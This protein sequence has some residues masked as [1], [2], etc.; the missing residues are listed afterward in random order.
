VSHP[1]SLDVSA[2]VLKAVTGWIARHRRRP[3]SRPAQRAGTVH[4]Q[5]TLVLRWL[6]HRLD[7]RTLAADAGL[8]MAT[9]YRYLHE[10]L[11]VIADHSPTLDDVLDR[12]HAAGLPFICLDGTLIP[13]DRVAARAERGHH[14]WY[15]GKHHAFGGNLQVIF[16]PTGFPLWVSDVRPGSTH[17]LTA[18][19]ELVLP[20]LYP[21]AAR[22]LPGLTDKGYTGAG[23]GIHVPIKHQPGGV[24]HIDNRCYNQLITALRA[25]AERGNALLGRWRALDRVT[26]CP[27]RIGAIAAAA[28]VLTS[29][30][31]GSR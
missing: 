31:R 22:G 2:S 20:A 4:A 7:L 29:L 10:A 17:D 11:D 15:S 1:A 12:A 24:L 9:A 14:L 5:V 21:H 30:D 18:A 23:V 27:Q 26:L 25:P 28:L 6:R 3:G 13:T 19:R 8:S 16:D